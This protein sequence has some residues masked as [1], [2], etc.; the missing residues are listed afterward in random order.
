M[1]LDTSYRFS[2]HIGLHD[3]NKRSD[4]SSPRGR[5]K[6]AALQYTSVSARQNFML[7]P[8]LFA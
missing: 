7:D 2:N 5:K 8:E 3:V 6:I 4:N 1:P